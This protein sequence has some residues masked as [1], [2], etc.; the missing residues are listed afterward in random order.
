M[1]WKYAN[2]VFA[3]NWQLAPLKIAQNASYFWVLS[4]RCERNTCAIEWTQCAEY[5]QQKWF[6]QSD[7]NNSADASMQGLLD[8]KGSSKAAELNISQ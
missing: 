6:T 1:F 3:E 5:D 7:L 4:E 8:E 2:I